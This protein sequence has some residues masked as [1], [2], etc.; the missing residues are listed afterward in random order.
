MAEAT[1]LGH[2]QGP[3]KAPSPWSVLVVTT[4]VQVMISGGTLTPPVLAPEAAGDVGLPARLIGFYTSIVYL[5]AMLTSVPTGS[6]VTRFGA[7]RTSQACLG[8]IALGLALLALAEP[9]LA[10]LGALVVGFGYG[11]VTPASTHMLAKT[12]PA[13]HRGVVFSLKQTGVPLGGMAAGVVVPPLVL[14][15]GWQAAVLVVAGAALTTLA[16]VQPWRRPLDGDRRPD[17]PLRLKALVGPLALVWRQRDLRLLALASFTFAAIQLSLSTFLV[18]YLVE[19]AG[20]DLVTAGLIF[21]IAQAGGVVGRVIWGALADRWVGG[22]GTLVLVALG[23]AASALTVATAD[24]TWSTVA[25]TGVAI[26]FG[27][28]AVGWNGVWIAEVSH[29]A[30][31]GEAGTATGG[32]LFFTYGGVVFGPALFGLL[33]GLPGGYPLAFAVYA[34]AAA[35]GGV[36]I[37]RVKPA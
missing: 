10:L 34:G 3:I 1:N 5:G 8:L 20:R 33:A 30:P 15:L 4:L 25:L 19:V 28:T 17:Q 14:W 31:P 24:A 26:A 36:L 12:T 37:L 22:R 18:V 2:P 32:A 21:S 11:P 23:M 9:V 7:M 27:A 35:L 6:L 16:L 13:R 29:R